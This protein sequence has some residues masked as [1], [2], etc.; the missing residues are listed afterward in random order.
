M[1][2]DMRSLMELVPVAFHRLT[3]ASDAL[4]AT[5]G[6][7]AGMR[8]LLLSIQ[9]HGPTPVSKMA[10]M[11]PVSRQFIQR[12]ADQMVEGGWVTT[13]PNPA[14]RRSPLIALTP[15]GDAAIVA[16]AKAES[17][18]IA[19]LAEGIAPADIAA[20]QRVLATIAQRLSPDVIDALASEDAV[21]E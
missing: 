8:G 10:A 21:H 17:P 3:A 20:A 6:L 11:R 1:D 19:R 7:T 4:H 2:V 9:R 14:H 13:L 15:K 5:S 16:I 12:L 18:Q